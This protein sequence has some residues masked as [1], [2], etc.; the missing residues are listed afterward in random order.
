MQN[1]VDLEIH[2]HKLE[3]AGYPVEVTLDHDQVY[4]G[5]YL[6]ADIV[7]WVL[8]GNTIEDG[9]HLFKALF[10]DD[11]PKSAWI[12]AR[13]RASDQNVERRVRL[14]I[15]V[16][17]AELHALPWELLYVPD[18]NILIS[19]AP[20]TPF[21]RFLPVALPWRGEVEDATIRVLVAISNPDD[22]EKYKL[23]SLDVAQ[24]R[25]TLAD[26]MKAEDEGK[27]AYALEITF[28]DT[29]I[30]LERLEEALQDGYH[31][32]HYLG[33]GVFNQRRQQAALYLQDEAGHAKIT[34]DDELVQMVARQ[35]IRPLLIFLAA[36]QSAVRS[37]RD[38]FLGLG[39]KFIQAGVPAVVAMQDF[40]AV[41]TARKL[42]RRF[43]QRLVRHGQ[44]DK[45]M[46]EARSVLM[47]AGHSDAA[48]PA[49]L[50][51]LKYGGVWSSEADA[52]G[53]PLGQKTESFWE[54]LIEIIEK[55]QCLPIIGPRVHGRWLP[56]TSEIARQWAEQY[57][58]PFKD[59]DVL[60]SVAQYRASKSN[61]GRGAIQNALLE[62][63]LEEFKTRLPP[64]LQELLSEEDDEDSASTG[65]GRRG[66]RSRRS[67][68][69][70]LTEL[71]KAVGWEN[72]AAD[73]PNEYHTVLASLE[74][75][76]YI[77]TNI[78]SFMSEALKVYDL[79]PDR[80]ICRWNEN[81]DHLSSL[82]EDDH[83]VPTLEKPLVYHLFG[84]DEVPDSLIVTED[85]YMQFLV[86][87]TADM[88]RIPNYIRGALSNG[89]LMFIGYSLSDWEFK[90]VMN[91]LISSSDQRRRFKHVAVQL[92]AD[93]FSPDNTADVQD[94]MA[95]YF[96]DAN[97]NV[98]WGTPEQFIA[99]LRE[100]W[101][102]GD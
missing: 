44:V 60:G 75:P 84:S 90:V 96:Q 11:Q 71:V 98:F 64:E 63:L 1:F 99:E 89:L 26:V 35:Q 56:T 52:R 100:W 33:H 16:N 47:S 29:P 57:R 30:T 31:I 13:Q 97:I 77:T 62:T 36:C 27:N 42:N 9:Q 41:E 6:T 53:I 66:R 88:D 34:R 82:F 74:L 78:D 72:L 55:G 80:E 65:R 67:A 54:D 7:S 87:T 23:A 83:Y 58:Y 68:K 10:A 61:L 14:R 2:I 101:E 4:L 81:I 70:T 18:E 15:D 86:K 76:L 8:S 95:Q 48:V 28:L 5:G 92:E 21:S 46:N 43:Y 45:A 17:A 22:L 93:A 50:T 73:N 19:A 3:A 37:T 51:R 59:K 32:L 85:D 91:G 79:D 24:E 39:P 94:F 102:A 12:A 49:L 69:K 25:A 38:A 40:V 20:G